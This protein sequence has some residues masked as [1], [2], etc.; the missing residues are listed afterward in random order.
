MQK[1]FKNGDCPVIV[2]KCVNF[3]KPKGLNRHQFQALPK[4]TN[5]G[6][7]EII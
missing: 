5:A 1:G 4:S 7:G 3:M 6:K 2:I